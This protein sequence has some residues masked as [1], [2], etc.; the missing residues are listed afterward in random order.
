MT[1]PEDRDSTSPA[2]NVGKYGLPCPDIGEIYKNLAKQSRAKEYLGNEILMITTFIAVFSS[3]RRFR[4][5]ETIVS[6]LL[7]RSLK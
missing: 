1:A 3:R 2:S 6:P 5:K 7:M 4:G